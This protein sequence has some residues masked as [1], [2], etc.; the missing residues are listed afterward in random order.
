M[1]LAVLLASLLLLSAC[2]EM[3]SNA[4]HVFEKAFSMQAP[5]EGVVAV[6]GYRMERKKF[7]VTTEQ[8]WRL[9]LAGPSARRFVR[10]QWP[11][12]RLG[13]PRV[14]FQGTQTPWF[15]PRKDVQYFTYVS[16]KNPGVTVMET[17]ASDE[18]F[19]AYDG[20]R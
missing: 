19:I 5:P 13:V 16:V 2:S 18:V 10:Q 20:P 6:H 7:F 15:A 3:D 17:D 12:L 9:H 1:R 14:F 8:M 4:A 11:D